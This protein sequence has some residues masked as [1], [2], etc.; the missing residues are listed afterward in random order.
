MSTLHNQNRLETVT[1]VRLSAAVDAAAE[2][3]AQLSELNELRERVRKAELSAHHAQPRIEEAPGCEAGGPVVLLPPHQPPCMRGDPLPVTLPD[4]SA[5]A[6][7]RSPPWMM[8]KAGRCGAFSR[9]PNSTQFQS[10]W[11]FLTNFTKSW[12]P[13]RPSHFI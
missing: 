12:C 2:L 4:R 5:P 10:S 13:I 9:V 1:D 6:P 8:R 11:C 7:H 3:T